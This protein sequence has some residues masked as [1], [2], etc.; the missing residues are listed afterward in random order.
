M[1]TRQIRRGGKRSKKIRNVD[2]ST[3]T[4][5][6]LKG[7]FE[8]VG[9]K[10]PK[11]KITKKDQKE[12]ASTSSSDDDSYNSVPPSTTSTPENK[13]EKKKGDEAEVS[14]LYS[15]LKY[16]IGTGRFIVAL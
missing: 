7:E 8:K 3:N 9:G 4:K 15:C 16:H 14:S 12:E 13:Q 1:R 10:G 5:K 2:A 6:T 11:D